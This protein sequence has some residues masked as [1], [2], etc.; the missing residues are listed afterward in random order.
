[1]RRLRQDAGLPL[2]AQEAL[3]V[4]SEAVAGAAVE[5]ELVEEPEVVEVAVE[6]EAVA[7]RLLRPRR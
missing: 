2:R 1:M 7:V 6:E 3:G 4:R 5:A